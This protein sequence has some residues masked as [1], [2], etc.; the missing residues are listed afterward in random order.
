MDTQDLKNKVKK[1]LDSRQIQK[2]RI[3]ANFLEREQEQETR[4]SN[5]EP[6]IQTM[7]EHQKELEPII[8]SAKE[9]QFTN[10]FTSQSIQH[11][12]SNESDESDEMEE[13]ESESKEIGDIYNK[14]GKWIQQL[15]LMYRNPKENKTTTY[16]AD[17]KGFIG[18]YGRLNIEKLFNQNKIHLKVNNK[19]VMEVPEKE[20]TVCLVGLLMLPFGD[21]KKLRDEITIK[22]RDKLNY[23][24][25]MK[26]A[27]FHPSRNPKY[28]QII[29]P[30]NDQL[31][32]YEKQEE[33]EIQGTGVFVY[34]K[35]EDLMNRLVLLN[36]SVQ[37]GN[38]SQELKKEIRVIL[39]EM[40]N[41]QYINPKIHD[42]LYKKF[43]FIA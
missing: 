17:I 16:E 3:D 33:E 19:T 28:T 32:Y 34:Q 22:S 41:K 9:H 27:G 12:Q 5:F 36:G 31:D 13:S 35:P 39:D 18:D 15:M 37:A 24:R 26:L 21:F 7:K 29:K 11:L 25:I 6:I 4:R 38:T 20:T 42:L 2:E 1:I 40:M 43:N 10:Q 14:T 30:L 23:F 8:K